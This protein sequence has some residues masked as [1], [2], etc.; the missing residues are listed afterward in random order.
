MITQ[1]KS[2]NSAPQLRIQKQVFWGLPSLSLT[3]KGSW[4][5]WGRVTK[6]PTPVP[7]INW[8]DSSLK[9]P[10]LCWWGH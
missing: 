9:W 3:I 5:P 6:P 7:P 4:I 1:R 8:K 10:T 2:S